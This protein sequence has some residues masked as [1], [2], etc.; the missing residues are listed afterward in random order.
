MKSEMSV[1]RRLLAVY[2]CLTGKYTDILTYIQT[3]VKKKGEK[4]C[5]FGHPLKAF[6]REIVKRYLTLL[7]LAP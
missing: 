5:F 7:G 1:F 4:K 6:P 3:K 2:V